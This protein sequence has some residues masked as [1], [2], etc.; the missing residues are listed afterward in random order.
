MDSGESVRLERP[1]GA[2]PWGLGGSVSLG[3]F[4][5]QEPPTVKPE[6]VN[7][8]RGRSNGGWSFI[9]A[10]SWA[11]GKTNVLAGSYQTSFGCGLKKDL[12]TNSKKHWLSNQVQYN[13]LSTQVAL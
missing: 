3:F 12:P 8:S 10:S 6:N 1:K 5:G 7:R 4:I 13:F 11:N 2:R 9:Q